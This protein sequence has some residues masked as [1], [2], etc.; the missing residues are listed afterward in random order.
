MDR[1]KTFINWSSGKDAA[2]ALYAMQRAQKLSVDLLLTTINA[3]YNRVSMHGLHRNL[4]EEQA[5]AIGI[6][7]EVVALDAN[8]TMEDYQ[9][10]MTEKMQTLKMLGYTHAGFGDI[11]LEDLKDYREAMLA[12]IGIK[13]VFPLWKRDTGQLLLDFIEAGF[14]A[15]VIC[16]NAKLLPKSF[17][18]RLLNRDFLEDLPKDVD[19]CGENGEFHTFCFDGPIFDSPVHFSKGDVLYKTYPAPQSGKGPK[20]DDYGFWFCD[21]RLSPQHEDTDSRTFY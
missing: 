13:T 18:G 11:F 20:R 14:K 5:K 19:A 9:R 1:P 17:C 2:M 16:C 8:P 15:I 10:L 4:L 6:P 12:P 21:L 3:E 7:L